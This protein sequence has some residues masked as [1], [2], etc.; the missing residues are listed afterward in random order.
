MSNPTIHPHPL[1]QEGWAI[2]VVGY[3]IVRPVSSRQGS[4]AVAS[5]LLLLG[6]GMWLGLRYDESVVEAVVAAALC[7]LATFG[8]VAARR[9]ARAD[10]SATA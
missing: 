7:G 5:A 9:S 8:L 2:A 10:R 3:L 1:R 4:A 6:A